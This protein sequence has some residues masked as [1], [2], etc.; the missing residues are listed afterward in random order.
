MH[1]SNR[2]TG[3]STI[4]RICKSPGGYRPKPKNLRLAELR[5]KNDRIK[6]LNFTKCPYGPYDK[7]RAW[8][9]GW[10]DQNILM[11]QQP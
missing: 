9:R 11:L 2:N 4:G 3:S 1:L 8:E 10:E 7:Q 5:G 6:G